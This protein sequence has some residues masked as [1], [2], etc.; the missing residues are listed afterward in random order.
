MTKS[1]L[2]TEVPLASATAA[3]KV[4]AAAAAEADASKGEVKY[5]EGTG[6]ML[7]SLAAKSVGYEQLADEVALDLNDMSTQ[8]DDIAADKTIVKAV[9][10]T[11]ATASIADNKLT[12]TVP[13]PE[14]Y[15]LPVASDTVLGGVKLD[16]STITID[17]ESQK[18]SVKDGGIT[19]AKIANGV[20]G[21]DK[22]TENAKN[23]LTYTLPAATATTL[24][25]VYASVIS[26]DD[27]MDAKQ[28]AIGSVVAVENAGLKLSN[29]GAGRLTKEMLAT[30]VQQD[31]ANGVAA[32]TAAETNATNLTQEIADRKAAD[33]TLTTEVGK[34]A[35]AS[36]VYAKTETYTKSE[37]DDKVSAALT[38]AIVPKGSIAFASLPAPA[39]ANLG[40]MYNVTDAFTTTDSFVEGAGKAYAAGANVYVVNT[41][42]GGYKFDVFMGFVD[43]SGYQLKADM[44]AAATDADIDA[45]FA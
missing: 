45:M 1:A 9:E 17:A 15:T 25:G 40:F 6:L 13:T 5:K 35:D 12:I 36:D 44:P 11:G 38:S 23:S 24:G 4:F 14:K 20:I 37:V 30:A 29:I 3:G 2:A 22:L 7:T 21:L 31:I 18:I 16:E 42:E 26:G 43:L 28:T 19:A 8:L 34:K 10:A 27:A 32:K 41:G 39:A 33:A